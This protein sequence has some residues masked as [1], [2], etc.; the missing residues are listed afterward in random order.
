M[1]LGVAE[2]YYPR[3]P[4][5]KAGTRSRGRRPG[6]HW[7][8]TKRRREGD[9]Q[10]LWEEGLGGRRTRGTLSRSGE[11]VRRTNGRRDKGKNKGTATVTNIRRQGENTR[12]G[13]V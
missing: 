13:G 4:W 1:P 7:G 5:S 2:S 6:G 10:S 8:G 9:S 3:V 12:Q 11:G